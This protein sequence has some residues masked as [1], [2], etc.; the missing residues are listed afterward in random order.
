MQEDMERAQ[1]IMDEIGGILSCYFNHNCTVFVTREKQIVSL[2]TKG[3]IS[4]K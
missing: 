1:L 3:T 4:E 2:E